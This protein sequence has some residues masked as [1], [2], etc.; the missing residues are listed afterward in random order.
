MQRSMWIC[1]LCLCA[2]SSS[3]RLQQQKLT[4]V[5]AN[6]R[7]QTRVFPGVDSIH[8]DFP[9]QTSC[10]KALGLEAA[11]VSLETFA[12][13]FQAAMK[14]PHLK[15]DPNFEGGACLY[16]FSAISWEDSDDLA[17][18]GGPYVAAIIDDIISD[19]ESA[20]DEDRIKI[21]VMALG[22]MYPFLD[23]GNKAKVL[24]TLIDVLKEFKDM[25]VYAAG[26]QLKTILPTLLPSIPSDLLPALMIA[27]TKAKQKTADRSGPSP[28]AKDHLFAMLGVVW[29][30][31]GVKMPPQ[32]NELPP[33][34]DE[35]K[36]IAMAASEE[37]ESDSYYDRFTRKLIRECI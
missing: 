28:G 9:A 3:A 31:E 18:H 19:G 15:E 35:L 27:A 12:P 6:T 24:A 2:L 20:I 17:T 36:E 5:K 32:F 14:D 8:Y 10:F 25:P 13:S 29:A 4:K 30:M 1:F 23:N 37:D 34:F 21:G 22:N 26:M 7:N 11:E 16:M 33:E